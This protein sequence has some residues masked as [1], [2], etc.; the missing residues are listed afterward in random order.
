MTAK[1]KQQQKMLWWV[2]P[3]LLKQMSLLHHHHGKES[4]EDPVQRCFVPGLRH[5]KEVRQAGN[6]GV[7]QLWEGT[8]TEMCA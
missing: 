3:H 2:G 6:G 5:L 8:Q 4:G 1:D 7:T